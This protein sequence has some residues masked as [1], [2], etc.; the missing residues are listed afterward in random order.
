MQETLEETA[1]NASAPALTPASNNLNMCMVR[2][3]PAFVRQL[4]LTVRS[5]M[6]RSWFIIP[7][8]RPLPRSIRFYL[9]V[10]LIDIIYMDYCR[11]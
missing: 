8:S 2:P 11:P 9:R 6:R 1:R 3:V 10:H 5:A 4:I 7:F